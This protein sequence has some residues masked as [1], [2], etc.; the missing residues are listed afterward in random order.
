[1]VV[2][3]M[4]IHAIAKSLATSCDTVCTA[5]LDLGWSLLTADATWSM[6][7]RRSACMNTAGFTAAS[8]D[9]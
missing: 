7:C 6:V 3:K 2:D 4:S 5:V 9:E 1:M 8:T